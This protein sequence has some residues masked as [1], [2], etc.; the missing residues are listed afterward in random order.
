MSELKFWY[1]L[2]AKEGVQFAMD[3]AFKAEKVGFDVVSHM[4]H[5]LFI[6]KDKGCIPEC[7]TMLTAV[8]ARTNLTVSPLVLCALFRNPALLAKMAATLDNLTGGRVYLGI[9]AGWW[10]EEFWAYGY[11][12]TSPKDRVDRT[13][14]AV[15][16]IKKLWTG[17]KVNFEGDFWTLKDCIMSPVPVQKENMPVWNGGSGPRMLK[18]TGELCDGWI[19]GGNDLDRF[20][21]SRDVV[22][23]HAGGREMSFATCF[24]VDDGKTNFGELGGKIEDMIDAGSTDIVLILRPDISNPDLLESCGDLIRNFR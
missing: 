11:E 20:K 21:R 17:D 1:H 6:S 2:P 10:E 16:I 23:G 12:F 22:L 9:G 7:W 24:Y 5:F 4:D 18:M 13:I 14:E 15:Q 19:S 8:A 3:C